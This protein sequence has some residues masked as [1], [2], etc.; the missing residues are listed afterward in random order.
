MYQILFLYSYDNVFKE[1]TDLQVKLWYTMIAR[2]I[3]TSS[4]LHKQ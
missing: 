1:M 2:L 3:Y 4:V